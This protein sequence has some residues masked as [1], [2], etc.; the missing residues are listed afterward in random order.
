MVLS[1]ILYQW[2][3]YKLNYLKVSCGTTYENKNL[4]EV[5]NITRPIVWFY[6]N[7]WQLILNSFSSIT[8]ISKQGQGRL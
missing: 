5:K 2:L 6:Q 3:K 1:E 8:K 4:S 7:I